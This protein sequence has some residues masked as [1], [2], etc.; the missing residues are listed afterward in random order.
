M[1]DN[2]QYMPQRSDWSEWTAADFEAARLQ[3]DIDDP[4]KQ[5]AYF[6]IGF[7]ALQGIISE[8]QARDEDQALLMTLTDGLNMAA[9][10]FEAHGYRDLRELCRYAEIG[11]REQR[12]LKHD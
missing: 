9:H 2:S 7:M 8:E 1:S 10:G 3:S 11:Q 4:A 12:L 5:F 6:L